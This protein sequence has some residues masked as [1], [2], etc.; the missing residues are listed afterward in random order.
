MPCTVTPSACSA[1]PACMKE[2]T[3]QSLM[4]PIAAPPSKATFSKSIVRLMGSCS[5]REQVSG[6]MVASSVS[7]VFRRNFRVSLP[8]VKC[9]TSKPFPRTPSSGTGIVRRVCTSTSPLARSSLARSPPR[10][11]RR[12]KTSRLPCRQP[13]WPFSCVRP[14]SKASRAAGNGPERTSAAPRWQQHSALSAGV[15]PPRATA[16]LASAKPSTVRPSA[17]SACDRLARGRPL[18]GSSA[19]A[20]EKRPAAARNSPVASRQSPSW[21][22][23]CALP[24][25]APAAS[26]ASSRT[27]SS[28]APPPCFAP[29]APDLEFPPP[30]F[31]IANLK[32]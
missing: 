26:R 25:S 23:F 11:T 18:L 4:V 31:P 28:S 6:V 32:L 16:A 7:V 17:S 29:F 20:S 3:G 24:R 30:F 22:S 15:G 2:A 19:A 27:S 14:L 8:T 5:R 9:T 21:L 1:M 13:L 12:V 10:R